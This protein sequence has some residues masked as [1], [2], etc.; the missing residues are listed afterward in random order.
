M[1]VTT[2][3]WPVTVNARSIG[4]QGV[5]SAGRWGA[6]FGEIEQRGGELGNAGLGE[7][8]GEDRRCTNPRL[9]P[10][11]RQQFRDLVRD[12]QRFVRGHQ[13]TLRHRDERAADPEQAGDFDMLAGLRLHALVRRDHQ[14]HRVDPGGAGDHRAHEA[15]VARHVDQVDLARFVRQVREAER[16]RDAARLLLGEAVGLGAGE[17]ADQRGLAVIDVADHAY[18]RSRRC[19]PAHRIA[20]SA[21]ASAGSS[22]SADGEHVEQQPSAG[23]APDHRRIARAERRRRRIAA[24]RGVERER[25][26]GNPLLGKRAAARER[27]GGDYLAL[28][29]CISQQ[30]RARLQRRLG[31]RQHAQ[32][33]HPPRRIAVQPQRRLER[34]EAHLVEP[35][36]AQQRV[37]AQ[38]IDSLLAPEHQP[39]LRAAEQ[40]VAAA[41]DHVGPRRERFGK[42]R[43]GGARSPRDQPAAEVRDD[44]EPVL[45]RQPRQGGDRGLLDEADGAEV[46][47]VDFEQHARLRPD[48]GSIVGEARA[49]WCC[50]PR[51]A[52]RRPGGSRRG[53]GSRHRS[54]PV[55]R[56]RRSLRRRRFPGQRALS[57]SRIAAAPLLTANPAS[58]PVTSASSGSSAAVREPRRPV[59][60]S[61]SRLLYPRATSPTAAIASS[62]N[63][64]RPRL[65]WI[66][67]PVALITCRNPGR[68]RFANSAPARC[69]SSSDPGAAAPSR[70]A[71]RAAASTRRSASVSAAAPYRCA[72]AAA[73]GNS[74]SFCTCGSA[75]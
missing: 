35:Q 59:A 9:D 28:P 34:G 72:S 20:F 67:I 30:G 64:A 15:F 60:R 23:D 12:Q 3:P 66:T 57:A 31:L 53:C 8:G 69:S 71:S 13:I 2:A 68:A 22:A 25:P 62:A 65:V 19:S 56:A 11:R 54:R 39:R 50:R 70:I 36:R 40:L 52:A 61:N 42:G 1:P 27:V 73:S 18:D 26:A 5:P 7:G 10:V 49:C 63:G 75:R 24:D 43:L 46:A 45:L 33:G 51:P 6:E 14:Q 47:L 55:P 44:L 21:S 29:Q 16:D 32:H 37:L 38:R 48:G 58:A 4:S 41:G 17:R 74:S